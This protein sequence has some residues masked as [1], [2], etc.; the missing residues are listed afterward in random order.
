MTWK[1]YK[2]WVDCQAVASIRGLGQLERAHGVFRD[3][4][5]RIDQPKRER[6]AVRNGEIPPDL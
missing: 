1:A 2:H 4:P 5:N 3:L 6:E